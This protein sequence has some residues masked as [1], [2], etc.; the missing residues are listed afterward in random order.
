MGKVLHL[1]YSKIIFVMQTMLVM[2]MV[3]FIMLF[4]LH[5]IANFN[6]MAF[7]FLYLSIELIYFI[8]ATAIKESFVFAIFI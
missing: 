1:L 8:K 4:A 6:F 3:D 5:E 7:P 2:W